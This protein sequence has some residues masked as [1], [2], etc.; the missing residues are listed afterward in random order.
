M[1][2]ILTTKEAEIRGISFQGH[3]REIIQE[4]LSQTKVGGVADLLNRHVSVAIKMH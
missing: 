4:T 3:P 1:P 2:V